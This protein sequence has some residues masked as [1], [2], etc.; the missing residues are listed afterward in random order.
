[1]PCSRDYGIA[2]KAFILSAFR[3]DNEIFNRPQREELAD[4]ELDDELCEPP[5]LHILPATAATNC[6]I[7]SNLC[8]WSYHV[9]PPQNMYNLVQEM[10]RVD[11]AR[12]LPPGHNWYEI[13]LSYP[14]F[15]SILVRVISQ[16]KKA[17]TTTNSLQHS[18]FYSLQRHQP[19]AFIVLWRSISSR[20]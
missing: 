18:L 7:S 9:G 4:L 19:D 10:G 1:M 8:Y 15:I 5:K 6:G 2:E 17:S 11:R 3:G 14:T 16:M 20:I 12:N 13:H